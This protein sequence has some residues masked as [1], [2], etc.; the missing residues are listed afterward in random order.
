MERLPMETEKILQ[1]FQKAKA[2]TLSV[3][4]LKALL[5][6]ADAY[7]TRIG[8]LSDAG[9]I[10]PCAWEEGKS[11]DIVIATGA[12]TAFRIT[13]T[14]RDYLAMLD[15]ERKQCTKEK[16]QNKKNGT[17]AEKKVPKNL[18]YDRHTSIIK[19]FSNIAALLGSIFAFL[20]QH[21]D[22]LIVWVKALFSR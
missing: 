22:Q 18:C 5:P 10:E 19:L 12:A 17:S 6:E 11:Y 16:Q 4:K 9:L 2:G 13:V 21:L 20:T 1:A 14:G 15:Q 7:Q 3:K 8:Q